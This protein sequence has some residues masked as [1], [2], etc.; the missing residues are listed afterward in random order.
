MCKLGVK[1]QAFHGEVFVGNHCKVILSKN[2]NNV[3]NFEELCNVLS[4][5]VEAKKHLIAV[6]TVYSQAH[7][8]MTH[9]NFMNEH[10][11]SQLVALTEKFGTIYPTFF[12][13]SYSITLKMHD[14]IFDVP[15]FVKNIRA[16]DFSVKKQAKV[17]IGFLM[18]NCSHCTE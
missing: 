16:S 11:I 9:R 5:N 1:R 12:C 14:F 13:L 18:W 3:Y 6:F 17:C 7:E 2:K 10:D 15:R 8:L 4:D